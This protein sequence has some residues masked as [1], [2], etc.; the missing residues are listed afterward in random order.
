MVNQIIR[1]CMRIISNFKDYYDCMVQYTND[2]DTVFVRN[3]GKFYEVNYNR[4]KN[5][6]CL[7]ELEHDAQLPKYYFVTG[8]PAKIYSQYSFGVIGFCRVNYPIVYD[9]YNHTIIYDFS[10]VQLSAWSRIQGKNSNEFYDTYKQQSVA[11]EM[12][13]AYG[14]IFLY[15]NGCMFL[16][17][18]YYGKQSCFV[19]K[20]IC[21]E[22]FGFAKIMPPEIAYNELQKYVYN[23]A[24]P[25]KPIPEMSNDV[26][27]EL[28]GFDK[29]HSF[30]KSKNGN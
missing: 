11:K 21:L 8:S 17:S 12:A 1:K 14:P 15:L 6:K 7:V 13:E 28:A 25:E 4:S 2:H 5:E 18:P 9:W 26:K 24:R 19:L 23:T 10:K 20:N 29:K 22:K 27:I 30:R 16:H 3:T